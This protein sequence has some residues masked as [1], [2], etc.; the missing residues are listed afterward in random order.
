M[1]A[2]LAL[3]FY[4]ALSEFSPSVVRAAVMIFT[5]YII[6]DNL[7]ALRLSVLHRRQR[8][9]NAGCKSVLSLNAGFQLSYMAV[10][11]LAALLPW[12]NRKIGI[13]EE[14]GT[15]GLIAEGLR[16]FAPLVITRSAW[17]LSPRTCSITFPLPP[18]LLI[19]L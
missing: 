2:A 9:G 10:F 11:C 18:S 16:L 4:A 1:I 15:N 19:F 17:L 5:P 7:P 14:K 12:A 13:M 3:F 6:K 8:A